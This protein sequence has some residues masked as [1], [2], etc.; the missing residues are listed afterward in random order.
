VAFRR[1]RTWG[2]EYGPLKRVVQ[3][4]FAH[5]RKTLANSLALAGLDRAR[6]DEAVAA[7]GLDR[8][9]RAEALEPETFLALAERLA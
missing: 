1:T 6:A 4:A 3:A 2:E 7:A 8:A 5:R 9:V